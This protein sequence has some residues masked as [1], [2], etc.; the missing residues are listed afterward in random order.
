MRDRTNQANTADSQNETTATEPQDLKTLVG[1]TPETKKAKCEK[2][3]EFDQQVIHVLGNKVE[4]HCPTCAAEREEADRKFR[5]EQ[6]II[7]QQRRVGHKLSISGIPPRF[8]SKTFDSYQPVCD[9][10]KLAL[11]ACRGYA[12]RFEDRLSQGGGLILC[13]APGTGKTHLACAIANYVINEFES[14]AKFSSVL[15][16]VRSVKETF[17]RDSE[18]SESRAYSDLNMPDLLILDEVGIQF[19]SETEKMILFEIV[20][21]RYQNM[22][23]TILISNLALNEL[24][25][26]I[27]E[28]VIDR[29]Y[30]G[31]GAVLSFDWKS[32]RKP[33]TG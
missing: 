23:P 33:V 1:S 13:G 20:N 24:S 8:S 27:G 7:D 10:S 28:R 2:H 6:R 25:D 3:G 19:G 17:S 11:K 32:Y 22:R 12:E 5:A 9:K 26:F 4:G 18:K 16:A 15:Q 29:M 21:G 31:G 30:E 14:Y